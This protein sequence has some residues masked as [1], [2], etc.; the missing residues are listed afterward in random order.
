MTRNSFQ[1]AAMNENHPDFQK[2]IKRQEPLYKRQNDLRSE[3]SRD[4]NRII[5]SLHHQ[6]GGS[7][8]P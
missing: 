3:F 8:H 7:L 1:T 4:Y 2:A 5:F 6:G